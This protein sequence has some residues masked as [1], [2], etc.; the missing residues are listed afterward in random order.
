[1]TLVEIM[2]ALVIGLVVIGAVVALYLGS[3]QTARFQAGV[4]R[5]QENG[6]FAVDLVSRSVRTWPVT[7]TRRPVSQS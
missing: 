2:V 6:R 1:L 5:V 3:S 7:M 4:L